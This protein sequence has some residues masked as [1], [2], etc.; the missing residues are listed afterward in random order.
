MT[1]RDAPSEIRRGRR[2]LEGMSNVEMTGP[3]A[4]HEGEGCW[5]IPLRLT[6]ADST[7]HV[8]SQTMWFALLEPE[9]PSGRVHLLPARVGGLVANFR[10]MENNLDGSGEWRLGSPCLDRPGRWLGSRDLVFQPTS[11]DELLRWHVERALEWLSAAA[12]NQL[13]D[14]SEPFELPPFDIGGSTFGFDEDA[15]GL[16][17][18]TGLFGRAGNAIVKSIKDGLFVA[19]A[20]RKGNAFVN[21]PRWGRRLAKNQNIVPAF[22]LALNDVPVTAPWNTPRTWGEMREICRVQKVDLEG[23]LKWMYHHLRSSNAFAISW[24][25][26]GFPIPDVYDGPAMR[27]HWQPIRLQPPI[28][29]EKRAFNVRK[30]RHASDAA[31]T[32]ERAHYFS[33]SHRIDWHSAEPWSEERLRV[34]GSVSERLRT[35]R[36]L[37]IGAGALGGCLA[38]LL[39]RAGV[40]D[41]IVSDGE[42]TEVGNLRRHVLTLDSVKVKKAQAL[43]KQLNSASVFAD[44]QGIFEFPNGLGKLREAASAAE[45]VIDC[46]ALDE[47][48]LKLATFPWAAESR[49]F[50]SGSLGVDARRLFCYAAHDRTFPV[51]DFLDAVGPFVDEERSLL[52]KRDPFSMQG[53]G[54]WNPVFPARWDDIVSLAARML[55]IIDA[56]VSQQVMT[57]ELHVVNVANA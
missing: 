6:I 5:Y 9:Y 33:D 18:W 15:A 47:V 54:C 21:E 23:R 53:A 22:W 26:V 37:L 30:G 36:V 46:T 34:R 16:K 40:R 11:A 52:E 7:A 20:M 38:D 17:A 3:L 55:R 51:S 56:S 12:R 1:E 44:V 13:T 27:M 50:F 35:A 57:P 25:L 8:P 32:F 42:M 28:D 10:H 4:F 14:V 2:A 45:I 24:L 39:I 41:M 29:I 48:A 43:E 19:Y 49:W 31:W